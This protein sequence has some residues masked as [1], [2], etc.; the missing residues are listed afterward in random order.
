MPTTPPISLAYA[1]D[2]LREWQRAL[3][4]CS[5]GQ[6][7][8]I[9][10]RSLTRQDVDTIHGQIRH[11]HNVVLNLEA[12]AAGRVRPMGAQAQFSAPGAGGGIMP[13]AVWRSGSN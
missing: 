9:A 5:S 13:G 10:G 1:Q 6:T 8:A 11:W 4:N 2:Q 12:L 3:E 7:Y